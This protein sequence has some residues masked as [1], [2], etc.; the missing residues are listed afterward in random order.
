MRQHPLPLPTPPFGQGRA[1]EGRTGVK[2]KESSPFPKNPK[3]TP[4]TPKGRQLGGG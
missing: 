4:L 3:A 1:G 2:G